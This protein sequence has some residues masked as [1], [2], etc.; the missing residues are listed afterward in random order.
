[1]SSTGC[2][3]RLITGRGGRGIGSILARYAD[4]DGYEKD[5]VRPY[6]W[7]YRHWVINALNQDMPF[8]QF[9]LEQIAGDLLPNATVEQRV[10]TGFHRNVLTNREAG[11]DRAEARFEQNINRTNTISTVWL[12]LTAGCAQCHNHKYDPISQSEYYQLFAYVA[13]IE[14]DDIDAPLPGEMGPYL[15]ARPEYDAKRAALLAEYD[16]APKQAVWEAKM[17]QAVE[18]PGSRYRVGLSRHQLPGDERQRD[19]DALHRT[20]AAKPAA[21]GANDCGISSAIP[22][23]RLRKT[24]RSKTS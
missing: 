2:S 20:G 12:G 8:D 22:D 14:E 19:E 9:T 6:A 21:A 18:N 4:S 11:V 17:R 24:R 13:D 16:I 3:L 23:R 5:L 15:K 7:R 10:A 1:M